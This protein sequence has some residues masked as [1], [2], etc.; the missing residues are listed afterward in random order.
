MAN[1]L[2]KIVVQDGILCHLRLPIGDDGEFIFECLARAELVRAALTAL[3]P[4]CVEMPGETVERATDEANRAMGNLHPPAEEYGVFRMPSE[5]MNAIENLRE[6]NE[7]LDN[8]VK[9]IEA[10]HHVWT[11]ISDMQALKE[12]VKMLEEISGVLGLVGKIAEAV[13]VT[14]DANPNPK[15]SSEIAVEIAEIIH[16]GGTVSPSSEL[17]L[18]YRLRKWDEAAKAREGKPT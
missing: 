6:A 16:N 5:M 12:R 1:T 2:R 4:G 7:A 11:A 8:R 9:D 15:S 10:A 14:Y 18:L 13:E 3:A 17:A